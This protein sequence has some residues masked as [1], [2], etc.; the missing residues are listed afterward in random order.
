MLFVFQFPPAPD[1][2]IFFFLT[3]NWFIKATKT[4]LNKIYKKENWAK[5]CGWLVFLFFF[6]HFYFFIII[7][8]LLFQAIKKGHAFL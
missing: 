4:T 2:T 7:Y 6:Q 1:F 3:K 8:F 5:Y